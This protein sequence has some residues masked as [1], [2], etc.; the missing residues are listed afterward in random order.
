MEKKLII[1]QHPKTNCQS[2]IGTLTFS[3][4]VCVVI[5][6]IVSDLHLEVAKEAVCALSNAK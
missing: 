5:N 3:A 2:Q 6:R 4:D 1:V